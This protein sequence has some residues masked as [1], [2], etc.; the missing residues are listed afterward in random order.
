MNFVIAQ[1]ARAY[2]PGT[3]PSQHQGWD[4]SSPSAARRIKIAS[5]KWTRGGH[6]GETSCFRFIRSLLGVRKAAELN[7]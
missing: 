5:A 2:R 6:G 3:N 4:A 1:E 7:R